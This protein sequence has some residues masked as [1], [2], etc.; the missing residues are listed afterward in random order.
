MALSHPG[1][2]SHELARAIADCLFCRIV[3]GDI[4]A[5]VV[6]E[7]ESTLAFRDIDPQAPTHVLVIPKEHYRD[8]GDLTRGNPELSSAVFAAAADAAAELGL[9][10]YRVVLNTGEQAGQSVF[11]VHAHLLGGRRLTWP[12]G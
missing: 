5:D 10:H 1:E 3:A 8:I 7:T 4:P 6:A 12:P 9:D 11:H 2:E